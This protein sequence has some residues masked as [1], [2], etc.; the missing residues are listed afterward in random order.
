M[1]NAIGFT[2]CEKPEK[3]INFHNSFDSIY[4]NNLNSEIGHV[5]RIN[6]RSTIFRFSLFEKKKKKES[7]SI[8]IWMK[9]GMR[10]VYAT[11]DI[12]ST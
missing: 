6:W 9:N 8:I 2:K 11:N 7:F 12:N 3:S 10:S 1:Q 5:L 4:S